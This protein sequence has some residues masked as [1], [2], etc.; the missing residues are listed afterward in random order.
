MP[1]LAQRAKIVSRFEGEPSEA[2]LPASRRQQEDV[3]T[4]QLAAPCLSAAA[5]A[6]ALP[7]W[8]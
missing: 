8:D 3:R 5:G 7:A 1:C 6:A 4:S 2:L